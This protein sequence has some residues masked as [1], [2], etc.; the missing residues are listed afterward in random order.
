MGLWGWL[1]VGFLVLGTL[2]AC[3]MF[4]A[5]CVVSGR[6]SRIEEEQHR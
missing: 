3:L 5:A 4:Y 1:M 2:A 6:I